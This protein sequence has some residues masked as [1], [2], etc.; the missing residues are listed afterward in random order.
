MKPTV[1]LERHRPECVA[2]AVSL[3]LSL[4]LIQ[5]DDAVNRDGVR[6]LLSAEAFARADWRE[7]F[8]TYRWPLYALLIATVHQAT[9]L[10]FDASAQCLDTV[11]YA[12]IAWAFVRIVATLGGIER[13]RWFAALFIL[14]L[15]SIN[16]YRTDV[17]R[18]PGFWAFYLVALLCLLQYLSHP[19]LAR[20]LGWGAA[21]TT[22]T[23]FRIEGAVFLLL[24]PL[25]AV[26]HVHGDRRVVARQL[27][28]LYA[29]A[30][31]SMVG[32]IGW[33]S[34][35]GHHGLVGRLTDPLIWLGK[36]LREASGGLAEKAELLA[37]SVLN[38]YSDDFALPG[39]VLLLALI[40]LTHTLKGLGLLGIW[41]GTR[42][43][44]AKLVPAP[45]E[46]KAVLTWTIVLNVAT[47]IVFVTTMFFLT[48]RYVIALVLVI[49]LYV[50]FGLDAAYAQWRA[51]QSTRSTADRA[52]IIA[53]L[54][55]V[56]YMA[57]DCLWSFGASKAYLRNAGLWIAT[58]IPTQARLYSPDTIVAYYADRGTRT[59]KSRKQW[60]A[61]ENIVE[62]GD[63]SGWDY[64]ALVV[65]QDEKLPDEL[66]DAPVLKEFANERDDR[67]LIFRVSDLPS[68]H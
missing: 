13:V 33:L 45:R 26:W 19:S 7:A 6:Y 37:E 64:L 4:W 38:R 59:L 9:G 66:A 24:L 68:T 43:W 40:T 58:N 53:I 57:I 3:L 62:R 17:I 25:A 39:V 10:A 63:L 34:W 2:V 65:K 56:L 46:M 30:L 49:G 60:K 61:Q 67:V 28:Q 47:L 14:I 36:F 55:L 1:W 35:P 44:W 18:D 22:A 54:I 12:L 20:A 8:T 42:A 23:L 41:M 50:P 31:A 51:S 11:L 16:S 29:V 15:P 21:I 5:F 32:T 52:R 27:G 48:G